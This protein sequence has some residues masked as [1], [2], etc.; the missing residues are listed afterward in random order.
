MT[1]YLYFPLLLFPFVFSACNLINPK[2]QIP[3]YLHLE[4]F[5]FN[6]P[7]SNFTGS[8]S[9]AIPSAFVYVNDIIVGTFDLPCTVPVLMNKTSKVTVFPAVVNQGLKSYVF[10][11]PF[12]ETYSDTLVYNP[13][14]T[15]DITPKTSY[16]SSL[17]T[18]AFKMKINFEEGLQFKNLSGDT[19]MVLDASH[20]IEG[21]YS[22]TL[23]LDQAHKGSECITTNYFDWPVKDCYLEF[24]Y[25]S[26]IPFAI[27]IHAVDASGGVY[28]EYLAGFF[29][30]TGKN[31]I[32]INL[33]TFKKTYPSYTK[34]YLKVRANLDDDNGKYN[35][36]FVTLDNIKVISN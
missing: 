32:Y 34:L 1:K 29:P 12:Y 15:Q 6:N 16:K 9:H 11:Y 14:K 35:S 31:K 28:G 24:D 25:Q 13:G 10:Q 5:V 23:Y 8:A 20:L 18:T 30:K 7:D 4:P 26:S 36:G 17:G 22:G 33:T 2:E 3:T 19:T 21:K 27:G